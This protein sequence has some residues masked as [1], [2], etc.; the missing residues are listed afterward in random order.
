M[1]T[2]W[3]DHLGINRL[4]G[5]VTRAVMPAAL[6]ILGG[7]LGMALVAAAGTLSW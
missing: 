5:P 1:R 6:M 3:L 7:G 2:R 4:G